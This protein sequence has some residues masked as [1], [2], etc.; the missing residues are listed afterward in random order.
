MDCKIMDILALNPAFEVQGQPAVAEHL[1]T[2]EMS[3]SGTN[4]FLKF[5]Y[6][7]FGLTPAREVTFPNLLA[8]GGVE[9]FGLTQPGTASVDDVIEAVKG[10]VN[11]WA[12][13]QAGEILVPLSGGFDSRFLAWCLIDRDQAI[14]VS[15]GISPNQTNSFEVLMARDAARRLGLR[16]SIIELGDF[17]REVSQWYETFGVATHLHGMYHMEFYRK[18]KA[19]FPQ[20]TSVLSGIFGDIWSGK[21]SPGPITQPSGLL[22]LAL[23][24]GVA[25][26]ADE[27]REPAIADHVLEE[28]F[29]ASG[30]VGWNTRERIVA[31]W[32]LKSM[33]LRY[34]VEVPNNLGFSVGS[35][36]LSTEVVR[37]LL[38]LS[39]REWDNRRWQQDFFAR[40]QLGI[41]NQ[42]DFRNSLDLQGHRRLPGPRLDAEF[43]AEFV[44]RRVVESVNARLFPKRYRNLLLSKSD[45]DNKQR[46]RRD[47]WAYDKYVVLAALQMYGLGPGHESN[48]VWLKHSAALR[49]EDN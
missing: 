27:I 29:R 13:A 21:I 16:H 36:F 37:A 38:G 9:A 25:L 42:G 41:P 35:P 4:L 20:A 18:A 19:R 22:S 10:W 40:V 48:Q 11:D 49:P 6:S 5:G 32:L 23:S 34:L 7:T 8:N 24:H 33:L 1:Q 46:L 30:A 26:S 45:R 31:L 47:R 3:A 44:E 2:G 28:T 39:E 17:H 14:A 15:Y 43:L 12:R